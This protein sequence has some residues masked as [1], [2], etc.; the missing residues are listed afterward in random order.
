[1]ESRRAFSTS[2]IRDQAFFFFGFAAFFFASFGWVFL[3]AGFFGAG[4]FFASFFSGFS[5][6]FLEGA[7]FSFGAFFFSTGFFTAGSSIFTAAFL[8]GFGGALDL[9]STRA[10]MFSSYFERLFRSTAISSPLASD[11]ERP[12]LLSSFIENPF[13]SL[14]SILFQIFGRIIAFTLSA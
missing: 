13:P 11:N 14:N 8:R 7:F 10:A 1:M 3:T 4:F 2:T 9:T 6:S 5:A 12:A